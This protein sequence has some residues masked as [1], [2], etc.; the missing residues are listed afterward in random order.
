MMKFTRGSSRSS[1]RKASKVTKTFKLNPDQKE[2]IEA[3]IEKAKEKSNT[4]VDTVA[5]EYVC[6][7]Y[8]SNKQLSLDQQIGRLDGYSLQKLIVT[9]FKDVGFTAALTAVARAFPAVT[10]KSAVLIETDG[11]TKVS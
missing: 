7:E 9:L 3:A 10:V 6:L 1:H 8:L 4:T 11:M 5:L 2:T